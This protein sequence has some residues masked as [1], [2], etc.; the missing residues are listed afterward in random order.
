LEIDGRC[1]Q[2][3]A[4]ALALTAWRIGGAEL[5]LPVPHVAWVGAPPPLPR[6]EFAALANGDSDLRRGLET[7]HDLFAQAPL[8]G[9][10]IEVTGGDLVNPTRIARIEESIAALV[11]KMRGAEPERVEGALAA[12]GMADAAAILARRWTLIVTNVPFLGYR[13]MSG[14]L[15][16]WI[17]SNHGPTKGD[18]GY[19]LW[20][21]LLRCTEPF[22]AVAVV[23]LQHWRSAVS[24]TEFRRELL[25]NNSLC[26]VAYLGAGAFRSITGQKVNI[27]LS[28]CTTSSPVQE[29]MTAVHDCSVA[30][31]VDEKQSYMVSGPFA[32]IS[33][34]EQLANPAYTI[35]FHPREK[36]EALDKFAWCLAGIMNGD[37][38]RFV[39]HFW[40]VAEPHPLW[41]Y[42]QSTVDRRNFNGGRERI[43]FYDEQNGH[44][45]EDARIRRERLHNSDERGNQVWGKVGIAVNQMADL[46]VNYYFGN[47]Y[48]SNVAV[49][50][51]RVASDTQ[52]IAAFCTSET[53]SEEVRKIEQKLNI[54]NATFGR[55]A[56]DVGHWRKV[57]AIP[58]W[59][60]RSLLR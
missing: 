30:K 4:F 24:Y 26:L 15:V 25:S 59:A 57:G 33:Q 42:L 58:E 34:K 37:T 11:D 47:K 2:I 7:L 40:E 1:V 44:L 53:F 16:S 36:H 56:F 5:V 3:A 10:L 27:T 6:A 52:A 19:S 21:R 9:S 48:D 54:T 20:R 13:E 18:L 29:Q 46:S 8:L 31:D 23:T 51:P 45:R 39:A 22:G 38:P 35:T 55:L 32:L 28:I 14:D 43:V 12:R 60:T 49:I 41:A 50:V 17:S